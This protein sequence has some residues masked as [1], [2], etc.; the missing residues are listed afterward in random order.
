MYNLN[1]MNFSLTTQAIEL[2]ESG[3]DVCVVAESF[4][5]NTTSD[6]CGGFW[7]P[8]LVG[9]EPE[10]LHKICKYSFQKMLAMKA[11]N[12]DIGIRL[13]SGYEF[14]SS[15][16]EVPIWSDIVFGFRR[17]DANEIKSL[18]PHA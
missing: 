1:T 2:L 17:A 18:C 4:P 10:R 9:L 12:P 13:V 5:P 3:C 15:P 6:A 16:P 14:F 11:L 7:R 8:T